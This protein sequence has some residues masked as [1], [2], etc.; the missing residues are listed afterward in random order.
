MTEKVK[1]KM[2]MTKEEAQQAY[3]DLIAYRR[4]NVLVKS[5]EHPGMIEE[6]HIIPISIN[7]LDI[8]ENKIALLAKEHF[9]AHVYLWII[10]HDDEF[11]D[12]ML[13]AL[14]NMHK[15]T[16][17]GNR[18]ELR[19]FILMSEDYQQAREEFGKIASK[20]FS[21]TN[22]GEKNPNYGKSWYYNPETNESKSFKVGCQ[23]SG[24]KLG[25]KMKNIKDFSQKVSNNTKGR[26]WISNIYTNILKFVPKELAIQMV[27][28]NEWKYGYPSSEKEKRSIRLKQCNRHYQQQYIKNKKKFEQQ[29]YNELKPLY[30]E[31]LKNEFEGVVKK[32][33]YKHTRN[34]LIMA[35]KRYIPEYVPQKCNRWK[36]RK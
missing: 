25:R 22:K 5:K 23:P 12:Q 14:M 2:T 32:F 10:H 13:C 11:H 31:F 1:N 15:G 27:N 19:D 28:T 34:N 21:E 17:N 20:I 30:E 3:D 7:G 9:M 33:N 6:H 36:N 24:W 16:K 4:Q 29:K 35:F 18:K 26:K 8:D